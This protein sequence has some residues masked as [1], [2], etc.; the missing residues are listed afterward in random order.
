MNYTPLNYTPINTNFLRKRGERRKVSWVKIIGTVVG[1][2]FFLFVATFFAVAYSSFRPPFIS[3]DISK[4]IKVYTAFLPLLPKT[5]EQVV[6]ATV[7]KALKVKSFSLDASGSISISSAMM[8]DFN[9]DFR[10]KSKIEVVKEDQVNAESQVFISA[11][12]S[13]VNYELSFKAKEIG[14]ASYFKLESISDDLYKTVKELAKIFSPYSYFA[15]DTDFDQVKSKLLSS[16]IKVE[17]NSPDIPSR[18]EIQ[19]QRAEES[20][21]VYSQASELLVY[22]EFL[23]RASFSTTESGYV[24]YSDY[25][26]SEV[27]RIV[28]RYL[29]EKGEVLTKENQKNL[30][31][32]GNSIQTLKISVETDK[33]YNLT[34][35]TV[36]SAIDYNL[37]KADLS[38]VLI[39][40]NHNAQ[41][42]I[43]APESAVDIKDFVKEISSIFEKGNVLASSSTGGSG[44]TR[45]VLI[46]LGK[47]IEEY[48][49]EN[50][51]YP[52]GLNDLFE[53]FSETQKE[54]WKKA[55]LD[56]DV[57]YF[58]SSDKNS[59]IL[60]APYIK[61]SQVK[62]LV[63]EAGGVVKVASSE[64]LLRKVNSI[65]ADV[66]G[67]FV[68]RIVD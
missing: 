67:A 42:N 30:D 45:F 13:L 23:K 16:W 62:Y 3:K 60:Y 47:K 15:S 20:K 41:F 10:S 27:V 28:K 59:F 6:L 54:S 24:F 39:F 43:K 51:F 34:K 29:L 49:K 68:E 52:E 61:K 46:E 1:I 31:E 21:K 35:L 17:Q 55:V 40:S 14:N 58:V 9:V 65:K 12:N 63:Y 36:F 26:G 56:Y 38:A 2:I 19:K 5:K 48:K 32:I 25:S 4:R 11:K 22:D 33:K 8:N 57:K 66:L 53:N 44:Y 50:A 64:E 18:K 7:Y 37:Y